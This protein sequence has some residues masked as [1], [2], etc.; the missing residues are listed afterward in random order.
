MQLNEGVATRN[1]YQAN[2]KICKLHYTDDIN[3]LDY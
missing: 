1:V 2:V 3:L